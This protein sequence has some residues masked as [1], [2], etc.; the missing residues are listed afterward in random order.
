MPARPRSTGSGAGPA[1]PAS[2]PTTASSITVTATAGPRSPRAKIAR[3]SPT[4]TTAATSQPTP[5]VC[6]RYGSGGAAPVGRR[7]RGDRAAARRLGSSGGALAAVGGPVGRS[8]TPP[9][10]A[11]GG[12]RRPCLLAAGLSRRTT[13]RAV[14]PR[15]P[16]PDATGPRRRLRQSWKRARRCGAAAGGEAGG[17]PP[18]RMGKVS[19][20]VRQA[21]G[22]RATPWPRPLLRGRPLVVGPGPAPLVPGHRPGG[23]A[24]GRGRG[25]R[26]HLPGRQPPDHPGQPKGS[27]S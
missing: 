18:L 13:G 12:A 24:A 22:R 23:R 10:G 19:A 7:R 27:T 21:A 9:T 1:R 17:R 16:G 11:D 4:S 3:V 20:D 25:R 8:M 6:S 5:L 15:G 2:Q 26:R 14:R